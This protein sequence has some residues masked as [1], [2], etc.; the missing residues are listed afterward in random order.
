MVAT[1][2]SG[3]KSLAGHNVP[4]REPHSGVERWNMVEVELG[5]LYFR[6]R[7]FQKTEIRKEN[8]LAENSKMK[9]LKHKFLEDKYWSGFG[10][11]P[12]PTRDGTT[13]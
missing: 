6:T 5:V 2:R 9:N 12:K 13:V 7:D 10:I 1:L 11:D 3:S 4:D 8:K